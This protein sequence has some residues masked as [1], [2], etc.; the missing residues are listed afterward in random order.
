MPSANADAPRPKSTSNTARRGFGCQCLPAVAGDVQRA[1]ALPQQPEAVRRERDPGGIAGQ[2][3]AALLRVV[4]VFGGGGLLPRVPGV[5]S[6]ED[7][8]LLV[9][10]SRLASAD[11][12]AEPRRR[13]VEQ[14]GREGAARPLPP[15]PGAAR[16][17]RDEQRDAAVCAEE[18][19]EADPRRRPA[20]VR[21]LASG[22]LVP[23]MPGPPAVE[24]AP[25]VTHEPEQSRPWIRASGPAAPAN[26]CE[27]R[28]GRC[29]RRRWSARLH[30]VRIRTSRDRHSPTPTRPS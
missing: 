27:G 16:V 15:L 14:S 1:A 20:G 21:E 2:R 8:L 23:A 9:A 17:A 10:G 18:R 24:G 7:S 26:P 22:V 29:D 4:Q 28:R 25:G 3:D 12:P 11:E 6:A 30:R 19:G 13:K 5:A